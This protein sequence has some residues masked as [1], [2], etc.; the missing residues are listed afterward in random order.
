MGEET[1]QLEGGC[2]CLT[3]NKKAHNPRGDDC[4]KTVVGMQKQKPK[5]RLYCALGQ[6]Q[7]H[8]KNDQ[9]LRKY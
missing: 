1:F 3:R 2:L 6:E 7:G 5:E 8:G 4:V 9:H